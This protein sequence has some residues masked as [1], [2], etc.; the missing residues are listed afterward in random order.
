[1]E[2][3]GEV[4]QFGYLEEVE[5]A[6]T[7]AG[8]TVGLGVRTFVVF[9]MMD[10]LTLRLDLWAGDQNVSQRLGVLRVG[11]SIGRQRYLDLDAAKERRIG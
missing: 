8:V 5:V 2:V 10:D 11:P 3:V 1:M 6:A 9:A 4:E 7:A